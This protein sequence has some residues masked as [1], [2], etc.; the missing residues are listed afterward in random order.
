MVGSDGT[1]SNN[2]VV[3]IVAHAPTGVL[4]V[5]LVATVSASRC[6]KADSFAKTHRFICSNQTVEEFDL[7]W[8]D[9]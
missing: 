5:T 4:V 7:F 6:V 8:A 1:S 2:V 3:P 9:F